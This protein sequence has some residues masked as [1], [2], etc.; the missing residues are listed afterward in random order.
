M[1]QQIATQTTDVVIRLTGES[2]EGTVSLGD[3]MVQMLTAM[4]LDIYTYQTFPAEIKGGT[5]MYQIRAKSGP[6]LSHGDTADVLVALNDEGFG[7]FGD[8]LREGGILFY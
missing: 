4:G 7:L 1:T 6:I 3:L 2:G 8:A 5:V